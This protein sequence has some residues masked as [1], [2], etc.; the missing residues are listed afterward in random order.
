MAPRKGIGSLGVAGWVLVALGAL[1][2]LAGAGVLA[3][4]LAARDDDGYYSSPAERVTADGYAVT[5][6]DVDLSD[7]DA[8]EAIRS[9]IGRVRVQVDPAG[10]RSLFVGIA[11]TRDLDRYLDGV[12]YSEV[13]E[14][15][16]NDVRYEQHAGG[17]PATR[18]ARQDFWEASA[19]GFG[20][21][22]LDWEVDEGN[23]SIAVLNA[24]AA[25]GV[26]AK[27]SVAVKSKALLWVGLGLFALA[28]A[29]AGGGIAMVVA[30]RRRRSRLDA[31]G[32]P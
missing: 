3:V 12:A 24:D 26:D 5:V 19:D 4:H 20:E 31:A 8:V 11:R 13:N 29:M 14:V 17:A 1:A 32:P 23:W 2:A 10:E 18:P 28:L 9:V 25:Q 6:S 15:E 22:T 27:A 16:G 30:D 21:Q 7:D